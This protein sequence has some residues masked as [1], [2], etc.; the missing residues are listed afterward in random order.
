MKKSKIPYHYKSKEYSQMYYLLKKS[1]DIPIKN[2]VLPYHPIT[3]GSLREH[4]PIL[5]EDNRYI[6]YVTNRIW[7][8]MTE[9]YMKLTILNSYSYYRVK[10]KDTYISLRL[11]LIDNINQYI[12]NVD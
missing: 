4:E 1:G 8:K 10:C 7:S 12:N 3:A 2:M 6:F 9:K 11:N 5:Y